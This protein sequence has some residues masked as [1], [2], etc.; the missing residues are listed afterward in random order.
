MAEQVWKNFVN[1]LQII[2][3]PRYLRMAAE[4]RKAVI[5]NGDM[6]DSLQQD[7]VDSALA[8]SRS[9]HAQNPGLFQ[10]SIPS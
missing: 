3:I 9:V 10:E 7:A 1:D 6:A 8:V 5:K 4:A 2:N